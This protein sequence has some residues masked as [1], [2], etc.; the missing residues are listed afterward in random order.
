[1]RRRLLWFLGLFLLINA[2]QTRSFHFTSFHASSVGRA[3]DDQPEPECRNMACPGDVAAFSTVSYQ[4]TL[5]RAPDTNTLT[6]AT[7]PYNPTTNPHRGDVPGKMKRLAEDICGG[8]FAPSDY[9]SHTFEYIQNSQSKF[10]TRSHAGQ[11]NTNPHFATLRILDAY[12]GTNTSS[13]SYDVVLIQPMSTEL[14]DGATD[15]RVSA[16][17]ELLRMDRKAATA[18][19]RYVVQQTW[20]RRESGTYNQICTTIDDYGEEKIGMLETI[21]GTLK[22]MTR[23]VPT[24]FLIAPTGTAFVEFAKLACPGILPESTCE[25]DTSVNC[26]IWFG[27]EGKVSLYAES[28]DKE[29][30]HQSEEVGAWLAAAVLYGTVQSSSPCYLKATDLE[31]IMPTPENLAV[32]P[33]S[34]SIHTLVADAA[35]LALAKEFSDD[36]TACGSISPPGTD[37]KQFATWRSKERRRVRKSRAKFNKSV[38]NTY[39]FQAERNYASFQTIKVVDGVSEVPNSLTI[40][41]VFKKISRATSDAAVTGLAV[42]YG[43]RGVPRRVRITRSNGNDEVVRIKRVSTS[44]DPN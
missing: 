13:A 7:K 31:M 2:S 36:I 4:G 5:N 37:P 42:T 43:N 11:A 24:E 25:L 12:D 14:L 20:P 15:T 6:D 22:N 23:L 17:T 41:A 35:K 28:L 18:K 40:S 3:C 16:M 1:M 39:A 29:G 33:S 38:G 9:V 10:T 44:I 8:F 32:I 34:K 21:D 26:P 27:E 30:T 19:T